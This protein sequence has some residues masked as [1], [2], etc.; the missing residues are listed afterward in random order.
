MVCVNNSIFTRL[1]GKVGGM[2]FFT[3]WGRIYARKAASKIA[4]PQTPLQQRQRNRMSDVV[5]FYGIIRT[6]FLAA[7]WREAAR[8]KPYSGMNLF[9]Q[10]NIG[11]FDGNGQITD[12]TRLH[13]AAGPLPLCDCLKAVY[14]AG[15]RHVRLSWQNRTP[16]NPDRMSDR[17]VAVVVNCEG[18]FTVF[19]P[20]QL[21][22]FRRECAALI[23][24][25]E[26]EYAARW[27]YV[28]FADEA[29]KL[30]SDDIACPLND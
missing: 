29:G 24:L 6:T 16:L 10:R 21:Q 14:D 5:T 20:P 26:S 18:G 17:L 2:V 19:S 1:R 11:G 13:F 7:G 12:Y 30:F 27:I 9:I 8:G 23:T 22:C 15:E 3:R 25:P 4:N 28:A